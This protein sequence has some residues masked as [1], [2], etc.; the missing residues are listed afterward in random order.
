MFRLITLADIPEAAECFLSDK[1][2]CLGS[3]VLH[4][5]VDLMM[6]MCNTKLARVSGLERRSDGPISFFLLL[7]VGPGVFYA[8]G[9]VGTMFFWWVARA[10]GQ[11]YLTGFWRRRHAPISRCK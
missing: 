11:F 8:A 4:A 7:S 1:L 6:A 5:R 3:L 2:L 9:V 10:A